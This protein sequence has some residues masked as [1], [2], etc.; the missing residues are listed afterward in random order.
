[1]PG[2]RLLCSKTYGSYSSSENKLEI[3]D[4]LP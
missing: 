4:W 1:M 2:M 3:W